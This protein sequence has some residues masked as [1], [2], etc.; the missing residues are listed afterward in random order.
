VSVF[1]F[2]STVCSILC[3]HAYRTNIIND[4]HAYRHKIFYC[5]SLSFGHIIMEENKVSALSYVQICGTKN[6]V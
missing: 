1:G 4:M 5:I 6:S 3:F 2:N